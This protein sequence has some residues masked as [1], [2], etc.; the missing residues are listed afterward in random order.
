MCKYIIE[1][2]HNTRN[3]INH[4]SLQMQKPDLY[5]VSTWNSLTVLFHSHSIT[6]PQNS[7]D[8]V[9]TSTN[10]TVPVCKNVGVPYSQMRASRIFI[11]R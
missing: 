3:I 9:Y 6:V 8:R 4:G 5:Y 11:Y 2:S 1:N 7:S 10:V